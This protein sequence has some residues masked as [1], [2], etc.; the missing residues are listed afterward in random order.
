MTIGNSFVGSLE[1]AGYLNEV[2]KGTVNWG[3]SFE[4]Y[5]NAGRACMLDVESDLAIATG[6]L[7]NLEHICTTTMY[8]NNHEYH[9]KIPK[10]RMLNAL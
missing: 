1:S 7:V 6:A 4:L 9:I 8:A 2:L 5:P 3:F 10:H